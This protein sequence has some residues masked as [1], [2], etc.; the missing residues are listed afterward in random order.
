MIS[1]PTIFFKDRLNKAL[2]R[3]L[4]EEKV[5]QIEALLAQIETL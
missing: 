1:Q 3:G 2:I 5:S 4:D